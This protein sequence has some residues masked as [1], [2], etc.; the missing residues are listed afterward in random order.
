MAALATAMALAALLTSA[1]AMDHDHRIA[2]IEAS[3]NRSSTFGPASFHRYAGTPLHH[4]APALLLVGG[5]RALVRVLSKQADGSPPASAWAD[6]HVSE[7]GHHIAAIWVKEQNGRVVHLVETS[8]SC[9]RYLRTAP[10]V[11]ALDYLAP[12]EPS[13][14]FKLPRRS[15]NC[16]SDFIIMTLSVLENASRPSATA[17]C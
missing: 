3:I 17:F 16:L 11:F 12:R 5:G 4:H 15:E 13:T 6:L 8:A 2:M 10:D 1:T 7:P 14:D 9:S